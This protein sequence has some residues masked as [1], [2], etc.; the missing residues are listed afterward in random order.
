MFA[1]SDDKNEELVE[2]GDTIEITKAK[3]NTRKKRRLRVKTILQESLEVTILVGKDDNTANI[4]SIGVLIKLENNTSKTDGL[5]LKLTPKKNNKKGVIKFQSDIVNLPLEFIGASV[6]VIATDR[7]E[8]GEKI[9]ESY[10]ETFQLSGILISETITMTEPQLKLN[11]IKK[12]HCKVY[13]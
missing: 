5:F 13:F 9:G 11:M 1:C 7:N 6:K 3:N 4:S 2:D 12:N 8:K 10:S